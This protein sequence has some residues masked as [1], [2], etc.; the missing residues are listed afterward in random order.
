MAK[1]FLSSPDPRK[2]GKRPVPGSF[3]ASF[4]QLSNGRWTDSGLAGGLLLIEDPARECYTFQLVNLDTMRPSFQYE[5]YFNMDFL[6]LG[7]NMYAFEVDDCVL[8]FLFADEEQGR[9]FY[10][11]V[12]QYIPANKSKRGKQKK[13]KAPRSPAPFKNI[14][15]NIRPKA[16]ISAPQAVQQMNQMKLNEDG[17]LDM[18]T[19][20]KEWRMTLKQA[21]YRPKDLRDPKL[22]QSMLNIIEEQDMAQTLKEQNP[23]L[24]GMRTEEILNNYE[25]P[26]REQFREYAARE[27]EL[28]AQQLEYE[29]YEAEQRGL[30]KWENEHRA[31]VGIKE[32]TLARA[33]QNPNQRHNANQNRHRKG[34]RPIPRPKSEVSQL[35]TNTPLPRI[36]GEQDAYESVETSA[37]SNE[38]PRRKK[39]RVSYMEPLTQEREQGQKPKPKPKPKPRHK[40]Q[41]PGGNMDPARLP[42]SPK[43]AEMDDE[44][45]ENGEDDYYYL[46][47]PPPPPP[48]TVKKPPPRPMME[49]LAPLPKPKAKKKQVKKPQRMAHGLQ[50]QLQQVSLNPV[51]RVSQRLSQAM[52][53]RAPPKAQGPSFLSQIARGEI[54]L[55]ET[56]N[57][58]Q[59]TV[60]RVNQRLQENPEERTTIVRKLQEAIEQRRLAIGEMDSDSEDDDDWDIDD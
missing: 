56:G 49:S 23:Q 14:L 6:D 32:Q 47:L 13:Q 48:P 55:K 40:R 31:F 51:K 37:S 42:P 5:L 27:E 41:R 11:T 39:K 18:Q 29:A 52:G 16:P 36:P 33:K 28:K 38:K 7:G 57:W 43:M 1:M 59:T 4:P 24:Q 44:K 17:S 45:S 26:E 50:D 58:M 15:K 54:K 53:K 46:E 20:P 8:G 22:V 2:A 35:R 10:E 34:P 19:V 9:R 21:G 25:L 3:L 30:E 12:Y 60:K